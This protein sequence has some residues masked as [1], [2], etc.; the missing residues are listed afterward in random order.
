MIDVHSH[1]LPGM[2]D[3]SR[4]E[5]MSLEMLRRSAA[6]GVTVMFATPHFYADREDPDRFLERRAAA[7]ER[8]REAMRGQSGLPELRI[9]AEVHYYGGLTSSEA[10]MKLLMQGT[11]RIL[12]E[13]PFRDWDET[14]IRGIET[15]PMRGVQP[16]LAHIERYALFRND[17]L[18]DRFNESG[19]LLQVNG[20]VFEHW[21]T[22][23]RAARLILEGRVRLL[24]SDSHNLDSRPPNLGEAAA[25]MRKRCGQENTREFMEDAEELMRPR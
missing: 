10:A 15:M 4:D 11:H 2:D 24:G 7:E 1:V 14:M 13:M 9:G 20:E 3:G 6:D 19:A 18:I 12:I 23:R 17:R 16:I 21:G 5:A 25:A 8:L 22:A